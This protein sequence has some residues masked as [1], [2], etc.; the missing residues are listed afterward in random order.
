MGNPLLEV[1]NLHVEFGR[2]LNAVHAVNGVNLSLSQN[3]IVALVGESG[4]GKT[5]TAL[6]LGRLLP[7]QARWRAKTLQLQGKDLLAFSE[8][9]WRGVLGRQMTYVFQDPA[10][11]LNPVMTVEEQLLE[12][13]LIHR[14]LARAAAKVHALEA[15]RS[16][17]MSDP[18]EKLAF[19]PHQL[20]GGMQQRVMLAMAILLEPALLIAD[21]PTTALDVT[22]QRQILNLLSHLR[23]QKNLSILLITH[24]LLR[25]APIADRVAVMHQGQIVETAPT[26]KLLQSPRHPYT[27]ML[28]K[29]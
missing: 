21:E 22:V 10:T 24:D 17:Q 23:A 16:V 13:L 15:L 4:S 11:G 1:Q 19:Y 25:V 14:H 28:L 29:A 2:G 27:Q 6:A 7:A 5:L 18:E 8:S 26:Q 20:S 3:E 12:P 9:Q